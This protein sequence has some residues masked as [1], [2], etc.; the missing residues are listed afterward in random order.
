MRIFVI[1]NFYINQLFP[2]MLKLQKGKVMKGEYLMRIHK[3]RI[4]KN[5]W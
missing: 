2:L 1:Y 4:E 5:K 3:R